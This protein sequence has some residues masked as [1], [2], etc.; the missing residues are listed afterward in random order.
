M[1]RNEGVWEKVEDEESFDSVAG[2]D[3]FVDVHGYIHW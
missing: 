1:K 3:G 2:L